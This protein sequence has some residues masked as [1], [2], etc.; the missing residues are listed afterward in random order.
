MFRQLKL[1]G[2]MRSA[3]VWSVFGFAL[4]SLTVPAWSA[5][6][7]R[8]AT[9]SGS[10]CVIEP[11]PGQLDKVPMLNSNNPEV[12]QTEGVIVST[13]SPEGKAEPAAHLDYAFSG[14]FDIFA[15]HIAK[16]SD[17]KDLRTLFLGIIVH[18]PA[19]KPVTVRLLEGASYVS[20]PDAPFI[21][22]ASHLDNTDG[23]VFAGPGDRVTND[24][25]RHQKPSG[26]FPEIL[27]VAPGA[28]KLFAALPIP[29]AGLTPPL[30]GRSLL[31]RLDA[32]GPVQVATAAAFGISGP[33]GVETAPTDAQWLALVESGKFAGPREKPASV[34]GASGAFA[35]GR[36]A[37]VQEGTTW[38]ALV[39]NA[40][41]KKG[42]ILKLPGIGS[43][44][45]FPISSVE[46]G[47]FGTGQIQ[48]ARLLARVPET[49]Y[50]A[51][52]NYGVKYDITLPLANRNK[53]DVLAVI[54][55]QTP[56]KHDERGGGLK[57]NAAPPARVFFRGT[58][59]SS[60]VDSQG[61]R[62]EKYTHLAQRQGE[63]SVP[64]VAQYLKPDEERTVRLEFFYPPDAT[65]PQMVTVESTDPAVMPD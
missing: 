26:T 53:D 33:S 56:I 40:K 36:V 60:F 15:H 58:V 55:M 9:A 7:E 64:L 38:N 39:T 17:E 22:L 29:V 51:H 20:Q 8:Q 25:L 63:V 46:R 27:E 12:I 5:V 4:V 35:Y 42:P 57:F 16:A 11:L 13:L 47:T 2:R 44:I 65:P 62:H 30:N 48:S 10:S 21:T 34:P 45:S 14:R 19:R 6:A 32:S 41:G 50:A 61:I 28:S 23:T 24:L 1:L 37:G 3:V 52:G 49:A 43:S 18:N 31:V 59:K 54:K